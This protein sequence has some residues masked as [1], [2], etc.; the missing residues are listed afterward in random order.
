M[1]GFDLTGGITHDMDL[2][3]DHYR[4]KICVISPIKLYDYQ[5]S[6]NEE[7][8]TSEAFL[9]KKRLG[10]ASILTV[11]VTSGHHLRK[12]LRWA[13]THD[14]SE[15]CLVISC[16]TGRFYLNLTH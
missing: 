9:Y 10:I 16:Q 5:S 2:L 8:F 15:E 14:P 12:L 3:K 7:L 1:N 4:E 6:Q 13:Q 11:I